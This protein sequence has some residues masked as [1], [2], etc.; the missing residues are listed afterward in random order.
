MREKLAELLLKRCIKRGE[1]ILASGKRSNYYIDARIATLDPEGA[2]LIS[3][4]MLEKIFELPRVD[5]IG[6]LTLGADPIVSAVVMKS[7]L[8]GKPLA[9][10]IVRKK[11]KDHGT[12]RR[13]EG[14]LQK[15]WK[16]VV[17]DDVVT[18]GSSL[19]QAAEAAEAE[20]AEVVLAMAIVDREEGGAE[21]ISSRYP[22]FSIFKISQLLEGVK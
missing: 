6:G 3:E 11:E 18:S 12:G 15:G 22:F 19:L 2:H 9:G 20:G 14:N 7:Y 8:K 21:A 10:F 13:I 5:A 1:F 4:L 16:V 17:V